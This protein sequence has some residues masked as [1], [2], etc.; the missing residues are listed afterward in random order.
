[1]L[2]HLSFTMTNLNV[3]ISEDSIRKAKAKAALL[4]IDLKEYVEILINKN[5]ENISL[6]LNKELKNKK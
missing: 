6:E 2:N 5:T 4:G 1:M 3:D